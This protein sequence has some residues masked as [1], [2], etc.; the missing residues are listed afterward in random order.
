MNAIVQPDINRV[1][2]FPP[3][4][5]PNTKVLILGSMP[6]EKSLQMNQYYAH[7][8]NVLWRIMGDL[9]GA[10]RD[11]AYDVRVE[12]LLANGIGMWEVLESCHRPGSLDSAINPQT[13]QPNDF[14]A[15]YASHPKVTHVFFNGGLAADAFRR[16]VKPTLS[17]VYDYI[18]Y[19]RL[20]STSPAH[21]SRNYQQKLEA[22]RKVIDALTTER[23]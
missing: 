13:M 23:I 17:P 21:A 6:G 4:S 5:A 2:S 15:F 20:P 16:R 1:F 14:N 7:P 11:L 10:G 18:Q 19:E 12:K 22:W 9:I 3:I 8:Q